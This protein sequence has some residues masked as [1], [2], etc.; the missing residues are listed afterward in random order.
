MNSTLLQKRD[1]PRHVA[2][3]MDG[4]RRW[5]KKNKFHGFADYMMG[6]HWAGA[7]AL[8]PVVVAASEM[9]IETL[10]VWGLSTENLKRSPAELAILFHI[11]EV[12]LKE[13]RQKMIEEGVKFDCVGDFE[14]LPNN[15]RDE[16][17][18]TI[19]ATKEG[20]KIT[21]VV[22]INYGGRDDIRRACQ[23]IVGKC[24]L[25]ELTKEMIT[26]ETIQNHLYTAAYT[27]PDLMIRTSGEMRISNF[28]LW[29]FAYTEIYVTD[30]LWPDFTPEN[31]CQA[32]AHYQNRER[33]RGK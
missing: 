3:I 10:T 19:E 12:Y 18:N 17:K 9:G 13:N 24:E 5:G 7:S 27:D 14:A 26:E 32:V 25:G 2:I 1:I 23:T 22:A 6:G 15:V 21:L 28:L 31:L 4:N 20:K 33:R 30:V 11:Y 8:M 29:Q 16:I